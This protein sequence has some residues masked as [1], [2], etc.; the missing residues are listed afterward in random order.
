MAD[1]WHP[2]GYTP[3]TPN[4]SAWLTANYTAT[5]GAFQI[6][7][8]NNTEFNIGSAYNTSTFQFQPLI[9]GKYLITSAMDASITAATSAVV[10]L[11]LFK[12]GVEYKRAQRYDMGT[13]VQGNWTAT[14]SVIVDMNGSTDVID[15]RHFLS[16][17]GASAGRIVV[18]GQ[19]IGW[20]QG[21]RVSN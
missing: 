19:A 1:T 18:G 13:G 11:S 5:N 12:N 3:T 4:F 21:I 16:D 8:C 7:Q 6:F 14:L 15:V 17:G 10:I 9:A 2:V 20:I